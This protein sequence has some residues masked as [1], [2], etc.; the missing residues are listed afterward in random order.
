MS[1]DKIAGCTHR[2]HHR[3]EVLMDS[4]SF[5]RDLERAATPAPWATHLVDDT[6]VVAADGATIAETFS[7][8]GLVDDV[9]FFSPVERHE[10]DARFIAAMRNAMPGLLDELDR[11][12]RDLASA[13]AENA[14]L[15]RERDA[16][17]EVLRAEDRGSPIYKAVERVLDEHSAW[18]ARPNDAVTRA[19][20]H[21][22]CRIALAAGVAWM[23]R[24][25][26]DPS[27]EEIEMRLI[28]ARA[29]T[30]KLR[31]A[32]AQARQF[33]S[34]DLRGTLECVCRLDPDTRAPIESTI[35]P[36]D[37]PHVERIRNVLNAIDAALAEKEPEK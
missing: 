7:K 6:T 21:E 4:L 35:D 36:S 9:D 33:V 10:A 12:E 18:I 26:V 15:M 14:R 22:H 28:A 23:A 16:A 27:L 8:G 32:L 11:I 2:L 20:A 19:F 34:D 3:R 24:E 1:E 37:A 30:D 29:E 31:E 25:P 5:L 17:Q 13:R